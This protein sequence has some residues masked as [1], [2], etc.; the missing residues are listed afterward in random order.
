MKKLKIKRKFGK[1]QNQRIKTLV[2]AIGLLI[3]CCLVFVMLLAVTGGNKEIYKVDSRIKDIEKEQKA[4]NEQGIK[5]IGWLKVQG[6]T[7]DA[8]IISYDNVNALNN[9]TK[10]DFLSFCLFLRW[11]SCPSSL[12]D[13][14]K[15]A[16]I[17]TEW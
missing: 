12:P 11:L 7:I 15:T 1:K 16:T 3:C 4:E 10:E 13:V 17:K 2:L 14:K 9:T 5:T 8:P 6:T